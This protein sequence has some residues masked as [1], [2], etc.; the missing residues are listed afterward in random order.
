MVHEA[1]VM[2][3]VRPF[4]YVRVQS[5]STVAPP[6]PV[7]HRLPIVFIAVEDDPATG[8]RAGDR[9]VITPG[10]DVAVWHTRPLAPNYGRMLDLWEMGALTP[11][12]EAD[13]DAAATLR[14]GAPPPTSDAPAA[15]SAGVLPLSRPAPA[16][17]RRGL[18]LRLWRGGRPR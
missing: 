3:T 18:R 8:I 15:P 14:P 1:P 17:A 7:P 2:Y 5:D 13:A 12:S 11:A 6:P 10:A 16:A 9:V 4:G